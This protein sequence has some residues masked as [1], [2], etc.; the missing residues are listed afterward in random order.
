MDPGLG[1]TKVVIDYLT[2]LSHHE[3]Q[4]WAVI[5]PGVVLPEW[6]KQLARYGNEWAEVMH[7][8]SLGATVRDIAGGL[9]GWLDASEPDNGNPLLLL[10]NYEMYQSSAK[11]NSRWTSGRALAELLNPMVDGVILD[12]SHLVKS[13]SG[14][15][16]KNVRR[17]TAGK[18]T[19]CL[20]GTVAPH[21]LTD[22]WAQFEAISPSVWQ[23]DTYG[24]WARE[25]VIFGGFEGRVP[26]G[27]R[28]K[29]IHERIEPWTFSAKKAD[30]LDL[31]PLVEQPLHLPLETEE[32]RAYTQMRDDLFAL[33]EDE[34]V[35]TANSLTKWLNL[36]QI[37]SGFITKEDE[38]G[39]RATI[40][41]PASAK[42]RA[43]G[44]LLEGAAESGRKAVVYCQ[45]RHDVDAALGAVPAG[46]VAFRHDGRVPMEDRLRVREEFTQH[47]GAAVIVCQTQTASLGI[48][49][50]VASDYCIFYSLPTSRADWQQAIDR[51][52]RQGQ[53]GESVLVRYLLGQHTIDELILEAHRNRVA[54][55]ESLRRAI[56]EGTI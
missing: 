15:R 1:K 14:T 25:N 16:S 40:P 49:E 5:A 3:P 35:F 6:E 41:F 4:V 27:F 51:L 17:L 54:V 22:L 32:R 7:L 55:E 42:R 53:E 20:T 36:R 34:P 9:S 8:R 13:H 26:V 19:V 28:T 43:V 18:P 46:M 24:R 37:T 33:I 44:D 2:E 30:C 21:D 48:N 45:F 23:E 29:T 56:K 38:H 11:Y 12:E 52:H 47:E 50:F 39:Q 31:P 10:T